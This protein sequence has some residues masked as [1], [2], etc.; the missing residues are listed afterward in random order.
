MENSLPP[1]YDQSQTSLPQNVPYPSQPTLIGYDQQPPTYSAANYATQY[2]QK[3]APF[4]GHQVNM[5]SQ[6]PS[7]P[8][9]GAPY[10]PGFVQT[11]QGLGLPNNQVYNGGTVVIP[12]M[13]NY[14]QVPTSN[15]VVVSV[16]LIFT[17]GTSFF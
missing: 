1:S 2:S 13:Q 16:S 14:Q 8:Q 12:P 17:T 3:P 10:P 5:T 7:Q 11:Q 4:A 6:Y 15:T 9:V